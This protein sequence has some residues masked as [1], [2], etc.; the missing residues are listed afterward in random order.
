[1]ATNTSARKSFIYNFLIIFFFFSVIILSLG[2]FIY[3][4]EKSSFLKDKEDLL[5]FN[6]Q[7]KLQQ[8]LN[9]HKER[10]ADAE[11]VFS[12]DN[13]IAGIN[14]YF[15]SKNAEQKQI[16]L[17]LIN[18]FAENKEYEAVLI[19]DLSGKIL[20]CSKNKEEKL[21]KEENTFL[22]KSL[23]ERKIFFSDFF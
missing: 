2:Y 8:I 19:T 16:I 6:S 21:F 14:N 7:L 3:N 15:K 22:N 13:L 9:W 12:D 18:S 20:L 17:R 5:V 23:R 1:M 4:S 10:L 11:A